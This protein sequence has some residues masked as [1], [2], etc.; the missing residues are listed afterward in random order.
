MHK[1]ALNLEHNAL[2][3]TYT[4]TH[5]GANFLFTLIANVSI[6]LIEHTLAEIKQ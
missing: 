4:Q 6:T 2:A 5:T 3:I 1:Q